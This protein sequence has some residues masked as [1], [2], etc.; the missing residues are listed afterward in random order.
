MPALYLQPHQARKSEPT[1]YENLFGDTIERAF[2]SGVETLEGLVEFLNQQG[3]EPQDASV[4]WTV[5]SL[6]AEFKRLGDA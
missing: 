2:G 1:V 4:T 3:P 6:A 5:D